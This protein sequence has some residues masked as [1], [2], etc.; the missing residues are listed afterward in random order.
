MSGPTLNPMD[1][2]VL[3]QCLDFTRQMVSTSKF[4]KFNLKMPTGFSFDFTTTDPE[5]SRSRKGEFKKKSPSTLRRNAK[6]KQ[7]FSEK[8]TSPSI[9]ELSDEDFKCDQCNFQANCKVSLRKHIAKDHKLIPQ[10]DGAL[11]ESLVTKDK[12]SQTDTKSAVNEY[13]Q[14]DTA[15][16]NSGQSQ[17]CLMCSEVFESADE[18]VKHLF[19]TCAESLE[20]QLFAMGYGE[21]IKN[22]GLKVALGKSYQDQNRR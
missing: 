9:Q 18:M 13:S 10:L 20:S 1:N 16:T 6:R 17:S 12:E 2:S 11:E 21:V 14:T 19:T 7:A 22:E 5:P 3:S 8:K 4:F 15:K